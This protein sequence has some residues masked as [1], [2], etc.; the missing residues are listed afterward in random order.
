[1]VK[2][3]NPAGDWSKPELVMAGKGL[4]DP[5]AFWDDDGKAYLALA[6]AGSRAGVNSLLT[7]YPMN[8]AGMQVTGKGKH[9]FDGHDHHHTVEE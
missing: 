1:M 6:W 7:I 8:N 5:S 4:I 3:K 9:V 2:A